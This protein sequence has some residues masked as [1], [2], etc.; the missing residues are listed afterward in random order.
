MK[1]ELEGGKS[2]AQGSKDQGLIHTANRE[3]YWRYLTLGLG[4]R[5]DEFLCWTRQIGQAF[6]MDHG[7][8]MG[9]NRIGAFLRMMCRNHHFDDGVVLCTHDLIPIH[10][11][12]FPWQ[13][14]VQLGHAAMVKFTHLAL[15]HV[16]RYYVS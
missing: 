11:L 10:L 13:I 16:L 2:L 3:L 7:H 4:G 9:W 5:G 8:D 6:V 1:C 12:H 14:L 15:T